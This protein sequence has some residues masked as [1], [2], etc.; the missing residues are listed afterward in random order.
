M[1]CTECQNE[2]T[3]KCLDC[4]EPDRDEMVI[5]LQE[6]LQMESERIGGKPID[7]RGTKTDILPE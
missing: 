3:N 4:E 7:K 6:V 1:K 2:D 5:K